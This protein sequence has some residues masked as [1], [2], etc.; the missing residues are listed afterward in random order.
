[1]AGLQELLDCVQQSFSGNY[2]S[3]K[4]NFTYFYEKIAFELLHYS[5]I[6]IT[7][8][9]NTYNYVYKNTLAKK[10][11]DSSTYFTKYTYAILINKKIEPMQTNWV[12]SYV[13]SK[14]VESNKSLDYNKYFDEEYSMLE[15]YEFIDSPYKQENDK[16]N[17]EIIYNDICYSVCNFVNIRK[18]CS[19]GLVK[20]KLGDNY[21][22]RIFF[23][24]NKNY[25]EFCIPLK[26]SNANFLSIEY[27]HPIMENGI[28]IELDKAIYFEH[29]Q[30]LSPT[31]IKLYLE[32]QS[33][34]Y[35]FDMDYTLNI[36]DND[37][38]MF[39]LKSDK[40]VLLTE[41]GYNIK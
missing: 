20:M 30:I 26:S 11:I 18:T 14:S 2:N 5:T 31:F 22:Y 24:G 7:T 28:I 12:A 29:N 23:N 9:N 37:M 34:L 8:F 13:L 38:N 40:Y 39:E 27:I 21:I 4:E 25:E 6:F 10:I 36:I 32:H 19:E 33:E 3:L 1:M 41:S 35:H 17:C 16:L 15:S